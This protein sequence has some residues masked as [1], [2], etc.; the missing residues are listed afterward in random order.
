MNDYGK[1]VKIL[2]LFLACV[3]FFCSCNSDH[4]N[5]QVSNSINAGN[6]ILKVYFIDVGKG[7]A[8]LIG[9]PDNKWIMVDVG[10]KKEYAGV[11]RLLKLNSIDKLEAIFISHPHSDHAGGLEDILQNVICENIYT[12]P[13]EY[14]KD[15]QKLMEIAEAKGT[16]TIKLNVGDTL[17]ISNM[18][19]SV[20][21][22]NGT[23]PDENDNSLVFNLEWDGS[24]ILFAGD[25][26]FAAEE[27]LIRKGIP[28]DCDILKAG[29]H[30]KID[31]SS[32]NFIKKTS[33]NY[34]IITNDFAGE[35]NMKET[36]VRRFSESG[37]EAIVL[38]DA[39]TTLF[40]LENGEINKT[41]YLPQNNQIKKLTID[42]LDKELEFVRIINNLN[43]DI[44]LAGWSIHSD[45]GND[46]Y[47]FP[48]NIILKKGQ[49]IAVYSGKDYQPKPGELFWE[50]KNIWHD[51]KKDTAIL[52]D[53]YG[54]EIDRK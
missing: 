19:I 11:V 23:F 33:P 14:K 18:L 52:Y 43:E 17:E 36:S 12:T 10:P 49:S 24:S 25:Q 50:A 44:S 7:D 51:T 27:A 22:P 13:V 45:K 42:E 20:L 8:A 38:G 26:L 5:N 21:G 2:I 40:E 32:Q 53:K 1:K 4:N 37:A 46:T 16:N 48:D 3:L 6:G 54:R 34:C 47:F 39:G 31:A 30:G 35:E 28:I 9:T 29:H 15:S 41:K